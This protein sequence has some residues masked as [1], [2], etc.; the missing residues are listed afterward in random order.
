MPIEAMHDPRRK[1]GSFGSTDELPE[2]RMGNAA[3]RKIFVE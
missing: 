1:H 3:G 2:A